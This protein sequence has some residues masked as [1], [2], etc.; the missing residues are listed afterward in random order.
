MG[1]SEQLSSL[2]I[3][4]RREFFASEWAHGEIETFRVELVRELR[5][6]LAPR[7]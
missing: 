5:R 1:S 6:R 3:D 4:L 2:Q 7:E